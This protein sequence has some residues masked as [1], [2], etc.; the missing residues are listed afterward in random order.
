MLNSK[1]QLLVNSAAVAW[2]LLAAMAAK[3]KTGLKF[4]NL[5]ASKISLLWSLGAENLN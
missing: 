2:L 1:S 4:E 3:S 5:N